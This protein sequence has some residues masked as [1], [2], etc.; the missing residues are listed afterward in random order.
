MTILAALKAAEKL[1][2]SRRMQRLDRGRLRRARPRHLRRAAGGGE[3]ARRFALTPSAYP[4]T[5]GRAG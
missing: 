2:G 1:P 4:K 3:E 5:A